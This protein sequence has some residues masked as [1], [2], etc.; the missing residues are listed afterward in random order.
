MRIAND[1]KV[2]K[3]LDNAI[4]RESKQLR[5]KSIVVQAQ[6]VYEHAL[7]KN[8]LDTG[9]PVPPGDCLGKQKQKTISCIKNTVKETVRTEQAKLNNA[10]LQGL[11]KQ[12][13]FLKNS[14]FSVC[15]VL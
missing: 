15:M 14:L 4:E 13:E 7:E 12:S 5:K 9:I 1:P 8:T 11:L 2:N 10:H 3:A 6:T